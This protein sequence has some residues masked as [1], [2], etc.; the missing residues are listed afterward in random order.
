MLK[1]KVQNN[2]NEKKNQKTVRNRTYF[3]FVDDKA[4]FDKSIE[5]FYNETSLA[6]TDGLITDIGNIE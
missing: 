1:K 6:V 3:E 5:L 2:S 4:E